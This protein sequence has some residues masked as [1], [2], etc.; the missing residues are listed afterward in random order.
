M[1]TEMQTRL[2]Q[3]LEEYQAARSRLGTLSAELAAITATARSADRTVTATVNPQGELVELTIDPVLGARL[4]LKTVSARILE[5]SGLAA[6]QVREQVRG[7]M[8]DALPDNLRNL[9]GPD[10][11]IDVQGL[12]PTD[13]T[14]LLG[15]DR[16]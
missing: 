8:R 4:D 10:G 1:R 5:A 15:G 16:R 6:T 13:P 2:G 11:A 14:D 9:V 12:L 3:M 7:T